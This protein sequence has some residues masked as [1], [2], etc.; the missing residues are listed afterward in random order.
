MSQT[1]DLG[2]VDKSGGFGRCVFVLASQKQHVHF[3]GQHQDKRESHQGKKCEACPL[4]GFPLGFLCL[5]NWAPRQAHAPGTTAGHLGAGHWR[6]GHRGL[7]G[8]L[9]HLKGPSQDFQNVLF[10]GIGHPRDHHFGFRFKTHPLDLTWSEHD[11]VPSTEAGSGLLDGSEGLARRSPPPRPPGQRLGVRPGRHRGRQ[12]H[13]R[14]HRSLGPA[15]RKGPAPGGYIR[16]N[17]TTK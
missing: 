10:G 5:P 16:V 3:L 2:T 12:R 11:L 13:R 6:R 7:A 15:D 8:R 14:R 9:G 1:V 4:A 17:P